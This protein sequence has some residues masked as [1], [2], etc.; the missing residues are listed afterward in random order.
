[1][2]CLAGVGGHIDSFIESSKGSKIVVIDGCTVSCAKKIFEHLELPVTS[3]IVA[4]ELGIKKSSNFDLSKEYITRVCTRLKNSFSKLRT[5]HKLQGNKLL[6]CNISILHIPI[7][8]DFCG[9]PGQYPAF[10]VL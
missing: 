8:A 5:L 9:I 1:M 2:Y 6:V 10:L 3:Y 7:P 4:T